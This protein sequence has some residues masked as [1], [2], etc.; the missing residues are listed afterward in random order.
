MKVYEKV[1]K[2]KHFSE[3]T[4]LLDTAAISERVRIKKVG[5]DLRWSD[6][7]PSPLSDLRRSDRDPSPLPASPTPTVFQ[8]WTDP[9]RC[10]RL[11]RNAP[12]F[13]RRKSR[14]RFRRPTFPMLPTF[15]MLLEPI[16]QGISTTDW[17]IYF[18]ND[19]WC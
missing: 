2:I 6:L 17:T 7:D 19:N 16:S 8:P 10:N 14:D 13:K 5:P 3:L 4:L 15:Q 11:R 18:W 9:C 12:R 1:K